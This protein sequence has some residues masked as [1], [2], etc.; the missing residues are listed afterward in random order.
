MYYNVLRSFIV[1][2]RVAKV[3]FIDISSDNSKPPSQVAPQLPHMLLLS[4]SL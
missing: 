4:Q 2:T 3:F 1:P